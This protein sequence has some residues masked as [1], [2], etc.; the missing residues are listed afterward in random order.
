MLITDSLQRSTL[1][2]LLV[3]WIDGVDQYL[4]KYQIYFRAN[5]ISL[6]MN[7]IK[8]IEPYVCQISLGI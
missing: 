1:E 5:L 3:W 6:L 2:E 7:K 8:A 4:P